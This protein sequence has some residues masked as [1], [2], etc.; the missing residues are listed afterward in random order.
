MMPKEGA[1]DFG[2]NYKSL[3]VWKVIIIPTPGIPGAGSL[4]TQ[5]PPIRLG[6]RFMKG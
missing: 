4:F 1:G 2:R 5:A 3:K 6:P